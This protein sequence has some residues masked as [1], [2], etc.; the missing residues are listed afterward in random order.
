MAS[1]QQEK[2]VGFKRVQ[3][4]KA[5]T[6]GTGSYG[7]VCTV[8]CDDGLCA[9]KIIHPTLFDSDPPTLKV[10]APQR[11]HRLPT[12]RFEQEC[13]FLSTIRHPNIIQ[14]LGMYQDPDTH[15]PVLLMELMDDSLTHFLESS[16]QPIPYHIQ[17]NIC[18]DIS[19]ALRFLHSNGILHR[20]L[21][22]NN[23]LMIGNIRAK[24]TDFGM[25]RLGDMNPRATH[26]TF[27]MCP[28]TD[29]YMPP[30]AVKDKPVYT[31]KID[32]FSFGVI[33][34][35]I[36]TGLFPEP[37]GQQ[38]ELKVENVKIPISEFQQRQNHISK[39]H[40]LV[41]AL[42][43]LKGKDVERPSSEQL[44]EHIAS[45]KQSHK[46]NESVCVHEERSNELAQIV[47]LLQQQHAQEIESLQEIVQLQ[48]VNLKEKDK[49][50]KEKEETIIK[51]NE[52]IAAGLQE[53]QW[54]REQL[55][56]QKNVYD[57]KLLKLATQLANEK[58]RMYEQLS[59]SVQGDNE[60]TDG[61]Q[62]NYANQTK[63]H[64]KKF[65]AYPPYRIRL[66]GVK[67]ISESSDEE[68]CSRSVSPGEFR[69]LR[70][71]AVGSN[72]YKNPKPTKRNSSPSCNEENDEES[73]PHVTSVK[74]Q[75]KLTKLRPGDV[76]FNST[77]SE[78]S[79]VESLTDCSLVCSDN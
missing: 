31:E 29:V 14:Y 51:K 57:R 64:R 28:G 27:T 16:P 2:M 4:F 66:N 58:T 71:L 49:I 45:L 39:I 54:L 47:K 52:T 12:K 77:T 78:A 73:E 44:C 69:G 75:K 8:K 5:A 23:V 61:N 21:S 55:R 48:L 20:D 25:A 79:D 56:E 40:P 70:K 46:H 17:V 50:I 68:G 38:R 59:E 15:L 62:T 26:L 63:K 19:L 34:V 32:C 33:A 60:E 36:M 37:G 35:Q 72:K 74:R 22:S 43:R 9:A 41:T 13:E 3:V 6:L 10:I 7:A 67:W 65:G 1:Q 18:H 11:E 30:E 42:D 76:D 24:V 53:T